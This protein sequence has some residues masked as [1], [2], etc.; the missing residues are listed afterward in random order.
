MSLAKMTSKG[1][2]TVPKP[3]RQ[4]LELHTGDQVEFIIDE[5]GR[6]IMTSKTLDVEDIFGMLETNKQVSVD[7]MNKAIRRKIRERHL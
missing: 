1:Q 3:I 2:V 6:V 4:Y 7:D 5:K